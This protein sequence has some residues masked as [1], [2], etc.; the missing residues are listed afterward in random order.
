M[1]ETD[2]DIIGLLIFAVILFAMGFVYP[3]SRDPPRE[4]VVLVQSTVIP[5]LN[6]NVTLWVMLSGVE[7]SSLALRLRSG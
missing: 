4:E 1:K 2:R 3:E 6:S 5:F 7:A